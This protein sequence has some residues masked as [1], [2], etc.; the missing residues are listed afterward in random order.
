MNKNYIS[1]VRNIVLQ[2]VPLDKYAVFLFGSRATGNARKMSDIDVGILGNEPLNTI[3]KLDIEEDLDESIVPYKVDI[4]DF[5][6][7][8]TAFKKEALS[9]IQIWNCPESIRLS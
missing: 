2:K 5:F 9:E 6:R 8:D 7:M 1:V 4:I 3:I